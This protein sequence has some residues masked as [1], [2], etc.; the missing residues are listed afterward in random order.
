MKHSTFIIIPGLNDGRPFFKWFYRRIESWWS[1]NG[2][3]AVILIADWH[4]NEPYQ[5]KLKR[6][7]QEIQRLREQ[8][9]EVA[10]VGVSA[11]ATL[12]TIAF[13]RDDKKVIGLVT[14][15]G[16]LRPAPGDEKKTELIHKS[17][18]K[19][20]LASEK[21]IAGL[22]KAQKQ[23]IICL[24]P[25][26]DKVIRPELAFIPGAKRLKLWSNGHLQSIFVGLVGYRNAI[27]HFVSG[28]HAK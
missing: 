19:A 9:R 1:R 28:L 23:Q 3:T 6:I 20:A 7:H 10:L 2:A 8:G 25:V 4:N 18:Y 14:V 27:V 12:A 24:T 5:E 17:W 26:R 16:F 11:G 21:A 15:C 13:A 22:T